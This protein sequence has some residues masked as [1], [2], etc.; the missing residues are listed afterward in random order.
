[1]QISATSTEAQLASGINGT[2]TY[3]PLT[4][5]TGGSERVRL[6]TAGGFSVGTTSDPGAGAIIAAGN[7]TSNSDER[8]KANWRSVTP[9]FVEKLAAVKSGVYDRTDQKATQAGVSAQSLRDVLPETVL[10]DAS[11]RL[12]VAYG[13]AALV[14]CVELAKEVLKLRAEI[15]SLKG[16]K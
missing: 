15:D 11:G 2:G 4:L 5:Y 1:M 16:V 7:I 13:N 8:Y 10:E 14:A 6:S 12:S 9:N 3:L